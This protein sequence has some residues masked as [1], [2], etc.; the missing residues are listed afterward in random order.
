VEQLRHLLYGEGRP[1][2]RAE[3]RNFLRAR[4]QG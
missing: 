4:N 2:R 3:A 1:V